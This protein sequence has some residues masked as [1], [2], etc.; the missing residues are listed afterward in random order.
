MAS[1]EEEEVSE[2]EQEATEP[3][4]DAAGAGDAGAAATRGTA[5]GLDEQ[6]GSRP[7]SR[8]T[9]ASDETVSETDFTAL[10]HEAAAARA[11]KPARERAALPPAL[12]EAALATS[13]WVDLAHP[14]TL[15]EGVKL[16][17]MALI[18]LL[19]VG[20]V[21]AAV[22]MAKLPVL[23]MC[24]FRRL[25]HLPQSACHSP[26]LLAAAGAGG[27]GTL[28]LGGAGP[29]ATGPQAADSNEP[30]PVRIPWSALVLAVQQPQPARVG[31]MLVSVGVMAAHSLCPSAQ[32][33]PPSHPFCSA[34]LVQQWIHQWGRFLLFVAGFYWIPIRGWANMRAA[35]AE[36]CAAGLCG[37]GTN[38][39]AG[40]SCA[41]L[42]HWHAL[43]R[44]SFS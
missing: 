8:G 43:R 31:F 2:G 34:F 33:A 41:M 11:A 9:E 6:P 44:T 20:A 32:G 16:V 13:P 4:Q 3:A 1:E 42:A 27:G 26:T 24:C 30:L 37:P 39:R 7:A 17:L 21:A 36:R 35:E 19:K 23:C 40:C 29:A 15:Y 28:R 5:A 38:C 22:G 10:H 14:V 25:L 18:V 12:T